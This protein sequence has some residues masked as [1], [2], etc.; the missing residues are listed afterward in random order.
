[1]AQAYTKKSFSKSS[2]DREEP[3]RVGSVVNTQMKSKYFPMARL[4]SRV[5]AATEPFKTVLSTQKI[6]AG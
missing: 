4:S 6:I 3:D 1:M 5:L 2:S